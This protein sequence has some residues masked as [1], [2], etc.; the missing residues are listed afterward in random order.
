MLTSINSTPSTPLIPRRNLPSGA[1]ELRSTRT[2]PSSPR[3]P[4]EMLV[5]GSYTTGSALRSSSPADRDLETQRRLLGAGAFVPSPEWPVDHL[6]PTSPLSE[7]SHLQDE[8]EHESIRER[9]ARSPAP[10]SISPVDDSRDPPSEGALGL[11]FATAPSRIQHPPLPLPP[12]EEE[13]LPIVP[14]IT[15]RSRAA[16]VPQPRVLVL[17]TLTLVRPTPHP[18]F[19]PRT[20]RAYPQPHALEIA[21]EKIG[22]PS[23]SSPSSRLSD[24]ASPT[25]T[26]TPTPRHQPK[27]VTRRR[28]FGLWKDTVTV[29]EPATDDHDHDHDQIWAAWE[30]EQRRAR[31]MSIAAALDNKPRFA[32]VEPMAMEPISRVSSNNSSDESPVDTDHPDDCHGVSAFFRSLFHRRVRSH[33]RRPP[34]ARA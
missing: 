6:R 2:A 12:L 24:V 5:T 10:R 21:R 14:T 28:F 27:E 1:H 29:D 4:Y 19:T 23:P 3:K 26:L 25:L 20:T 7:A 9:A 18:L 31:E 30:R 32:Y 13:E 34:P 15:T 17:P 11:F 22:S 16:T 33:V 8:I